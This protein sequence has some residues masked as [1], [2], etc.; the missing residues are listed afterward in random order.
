[1]GRPQKLL[2]R[3]LHTLLGLA[4]IGERRV[5]QVGSPHAVAVASHTGKVGVNQLP[6]ALEFRRRRHQDQRADRFGFARP[7]DGFED[8][9]IS[10]AVGGVPADAPPVFFLAGVENKLLGATV[11]VESVGGE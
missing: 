8:E 5:E 1:M 4:E 7:C 11:T 3:F 6:D 9:A 2:P 10:L